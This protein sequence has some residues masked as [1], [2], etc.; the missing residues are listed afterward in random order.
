MGD[1]PEISVPSELLR[2]AAP[3]AGVIGAI[4]DLDQRT[5][6]GGRVEFT[7]VSGPAKGLPV[8][9]Y[10]QVPVCIETGTCP[11]P[12]FVPHYEQY[13]APPGSI[14]RMP[15]QMGVHEVIAS[16]REAARLAKGAAKEKRTDQDIARYVG[17]VW[18]AT[19][20]AIRGQGQW[21]P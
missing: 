4:R 11:E 19:Q 15:R 20:R 17:R 16:V 2:D 1:R 7:W 9:A 13:T 14:S 12:M 21:S 8:T 10:C 18:K 3:P 5:L 6:C